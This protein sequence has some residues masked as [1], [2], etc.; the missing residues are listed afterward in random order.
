MSRLVV[1]LPLHP[2]QAGDNFA[3]ADWPLH[4]TVLA[5]FLTDAA[6]ADIA[7]AIAAA[8]SGQ[9]ALTAVAGP[10]ELF[11]RRKDVPVTLVVDDGTLARLHRILVDAVRPFAAAPDEP[12]FTGPDFRAHVTV[13]R[14]ARAGEGD[15]L[16]LSQVALVDMAPRTGP[17]GRTVLATVSL[18]TP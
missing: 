11:G 1:V 13:K 8:V 15:V 14:N 3:V 4:I 5:P 17:S 9:A 10:E 18:P 6:P 2:L 12:A 16:S 7:A